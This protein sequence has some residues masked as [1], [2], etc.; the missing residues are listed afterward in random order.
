M[1]EMYSTILQMVVLC[2]CLF[3]KTTAKR[4]AHA[5][6]NPNEVSEYIEKCEELEDQVEKA[7][8]NCE[9]A[10]SQEAD[11]ESKRLLKILQDPILRTDERVLSLL[12]KVEGAELLN[13]LDWTSSVLY[14]ANHKLVK[15]ERISGT[16]EWLLNHM[17]YH[18]WQEASS[19]NILWLCGTGELNIA[20][21]LE[22]LTNGKVISGDWQNISYIKGH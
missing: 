4:V 11:A 17:S 21:L 1:I 14:G 18:E 6:F 20:R 8:H 10:R 7:A 5:V 19:S 22:P 15:E 16:C 3:S 13:I 9:R 12:Q 2:Y